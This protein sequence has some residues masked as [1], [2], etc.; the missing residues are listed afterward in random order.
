[1]ESSQSRGWVAV[2][3]GAAFI[4]QKFV[5]FGARNPHM[6]L[7]PPGGNRAMKVR[8]DF[9]VEALNRPGGGVASVNGLEGLECTLGIKDDEEGRVGQD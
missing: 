8:R 7:D 6:G 2:V 9:I 1:M 4:A 3:G 5:F